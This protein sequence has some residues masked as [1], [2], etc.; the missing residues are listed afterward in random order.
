MTVQDLERAK[1]ALFMEPDPEKCW[2]IMHDFLVQ[3]Q[4]EALRKLFTR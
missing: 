2:G 1:V 3:L 4:G